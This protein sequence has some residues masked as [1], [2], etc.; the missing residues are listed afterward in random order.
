MSRLSGIFAAN[1]RCFIP[2]VT[3]GHPDLD[4]SRRIILELAKAGSQIIEVGLPFSDPI[5]DGPVIQQSSFAALRHHYSVS[6]HIELVRQVRRDSDV[7]LIFMTYLNP[8]LRYGLKRLEDEA[9]EA[10]LDGIL[11]SDLTPEEY[12]R[13]DPIEKLDT[14]FLAAPTSSDSRLES[15][16]A[17]CR[18]F[19][20]LVARTGV[21]G[22][23]TDVGA[24]LVETLARIRRYSSLPVAVGFGISSAADVEKV[25]RHAEGAVVGTALVRFIE[26]NRENPNLAKAVG[27]YVRGSLL[28]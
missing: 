20:Y 18:G 1:R 21:T 8:V 26:E 22:R 14:V 4:S 28:P 27:E 25:W 9:A 17:I 6:D 7:G 16:A 5:A 11:I 19:L 15:I 23:H 3:S 10:G 24:G 12:R 13:M 2:F